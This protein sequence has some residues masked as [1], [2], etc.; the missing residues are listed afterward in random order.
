MNKKTIVLFL[1]LVL[2]L[3]IGGYFYKGLFTGKVIENNYMHTIALCNGTNYCKDYEVTCRGKNF[4]SK[5][6][7][8]FAV[9]NSKDWKD[10]RGN[11]SKNLC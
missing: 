5:S 2:L 9:Q 1:I 4:I 7:T 3:G 6:F 8:G 11:I 10:P